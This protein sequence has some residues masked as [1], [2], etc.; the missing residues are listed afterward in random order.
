MSLPFHRRCQRAGRTR[1]AYDAGA[2][3][4]MQR[5]KGITCDAA[6]PAL[7]LRSPRSTC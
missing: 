2:A 7:S 6:A 3:A 1:P 5:T 4:E